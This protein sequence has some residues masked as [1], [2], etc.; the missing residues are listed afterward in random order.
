M[1]KEARKQEG[2]LIKKKSVFK[3][4][5]AYSLLTCLL[6]FALPNPIPNPQSYQ[7]FLFTHTS[8][9]FS[10]LKYKNT[11]NY[12][13]YLK[14]FNHKLSCNKNIFFVLRSIKMSCELNCTYVLLKRVFRVIN[15][16]KK[17]LFAL[18]SYMPHN[19]KH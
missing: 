13:T 7:I 10:S 5:A 19:Y 17:I 9:Y 16:Y 15:Y 14:T 18:M 11:H 3:V 12:A 4:K 1:L 6:S 8:Y 2:R